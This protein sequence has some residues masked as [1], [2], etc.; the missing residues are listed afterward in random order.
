MVLARIA[1]CLD[2]SADPAGRQPIERGPALALALWIG[3][4]SRGATDP[5]PAAIVARGLPRSARRRLDLE[6]RRA[7]IV[8]RMRWRRRIERAVAAGPAAARRALL[9][10]CLHRPSTRLAV[11]G[12]L[13]RGAPNH[14]VL[15]S[16]GGRWQH[17]EVC[18]HLDRIARG[19]DRGLP[20]FRPD[21]AGPPVA[22]EILTS[23][24]LPAHWSRLDD[25][26]APAYR[27]TAVP[28]RLDDGRLRLAWLYARAEPALRDSML[29]VAVGA[30][31]R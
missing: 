15:E 11:Y 24:A 7:G 1:A 26:E 17:G 19:A 5:R 21:P 29:P 30:P 31:G 2:G 14:H 8:G 23:S 22:V 9:E 10:I 27:R 13:R 20:A 4:A 3:A 28:V 18:G 16:V 12:T 25:F 6:L